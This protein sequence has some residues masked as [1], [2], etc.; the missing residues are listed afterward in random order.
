VR[1]YGPSLPKGKPLA[2]LIES[3]VMREEG[4]LRKRIARWL[5][6][7]YYCEGYRRF[8]LVSPSYGHVAAYELDKD[9]RIPLQVQ[10]MLSIMSRVV[11]VLSSI[12]VRP[13]VNRQGNAIGAIRERAI[14]EILLNSGLSEQQ[15]EKQMP[16]LAELVAMLGC[17]GIHMGCVDD[18]VVGLTLDPEI[19]HPSE[20]LP[21]PS[22][23]FDKTKICG[24]IRQ[25]FVPMEWLRK[26]L[27]KSLDS[28][29]DHMDWFRKQIGE[30]VTIASD[31]SLNPTG[32]FNPAGGLLKGPGIA[33]DTDK[34]YYDAVRIREL[35]INGPRNT[36]RRYCITSG[37]AVLHD[38]S[39]EN[40]EV[41]CPLHK[42]GFM[43]NGS[44]WDAGLFDLLL[45]VAREFEKCVSHLVNTTYDLDEFPILVMPSGQMNER[46]MFT[47]GDRNLKVLTAS[48][49]AK[50]SGGT[51]FR[52]MVIEPPQRGDQAGRT[53][54]FLSGILDKQ[55]PVPDLIR[56]KGRGDSLPFMQFLDEESRKS[57]AF[58][59]QSITTA[60]AG[61]YQYGCAAMAQKVV[62]S[63]RPIPVKNVSLGLAGAVIDWDSGTVS[64]TKNPIPDASHLV[65]STMEESPRSTA[66]RKAEVVQ[67][68]QLHQDWERFVITALEEGLDFGMWL[69]AEQ[70]AYETVKMDLLS[71]YGDGQRSGEVVLTPHTVKPELMLRVVDAFLASPVVKVAS[72]IVQN[73]LIRY[74]KTLINYMGAVLPEPVP[75]P[76]DTALIRAA[77]QAGVRRQ[78]QLA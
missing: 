35:C 33:D 61:T 75:D 54:A 53:A 2:Q 67:M 69:G 48:L 49:E 23:S 74:R 58:A 34:Q 30:D 78:P 12:D 27:G 32:G 1:T 47:R 64:F 57:T 71:L 77:E 70:A 25:R 19:V 43:P 51:D 37:W 7:H 21:F 44:F 4:K 73:N 60:Y 10:E 46:K 20:L 14:A 6:A 50:Y 52:P 38:E 59:V 66:V 18:E 45:T 29:V 42:I 15:L 72:H 39:F 22:V 8:D 3:H 11:G 68:F 13:D 9:G 40:R 63:P 17:A 41:Y 65:F 16:V 56:Q 55:N 36:V 5:I 28:K 76:Y 62:E 31:G 26:T 24:I